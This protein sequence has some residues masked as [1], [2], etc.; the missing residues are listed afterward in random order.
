VIFFIQ[1][2]VKETGH[3]FY[4]VEE[5]I[6]ECL[7]AGVGINNRL[8]LKVSQDFTTFPNLHSYIPN[9]KETLLLR[10]ENSEELYNVAKSYKKKFIK[11]STLEVTKMTTFEQ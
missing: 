2:F 5:I 3:T 7:V 11:V 9:L 1:Y 6:S 4:R 8:W 10:A